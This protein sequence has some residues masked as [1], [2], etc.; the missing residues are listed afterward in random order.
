[1]PR[2]DHCTVLDKYGLNASTFYRVKVNR[3]AWNEP[4]AQD[5]ILKRSRG[6]RRGDN[7]LGV[8][9]EAAATEQGSDQPPQE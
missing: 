4:A 8:N 2:G 1:L 5:E 7:A 3:A 6:Y 9:A